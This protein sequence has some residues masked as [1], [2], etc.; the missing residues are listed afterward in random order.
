MGRVT[1]EISSDPEQ[2]VDYFFPPFV[3]EAAFQF[4]VIDSCRLETLT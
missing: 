3:P 2:E 4:S 1:A